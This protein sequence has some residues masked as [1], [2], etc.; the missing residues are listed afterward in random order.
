[1]FWEHPISLPLL[2]EVFSHICL[3][4]PPLCTWFESRKRIS[5]IWPPEV[6]VYDFCS[7][8]RVNKQAWICIFAT[9][10]ICSL[11]VV[12][13]L[14]CFSPLVWALSIPQ[15]H[16]QES[17]LPGFCTLCT[18]LSST[19]PS[20]HGR[21]AHIHNDANNMTSSD[22]REMP[23]IMGTQRNEGLYWRREGG[24][25]P[26]ETGLKDGVWFSLVSTR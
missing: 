1:M 18:S 3:K 11:F 12:F 23:N 14:P 26:G 19:I 15:G 22:G 21:Q 24:A 20:W 10:W 8:K 16:R 17:L 6:W 5:F 25:G 4:L 13:R 2:A 9:V 7:E